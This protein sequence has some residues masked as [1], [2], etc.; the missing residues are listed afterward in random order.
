MGV[1]ISGKGVLS[2]I[3]TLV[4]G[5]VNNFNLLVTRVIGYTNVP[6]TG[7]STY[8]TTRVGS[9]SP[10]FVTISRTGSL[11]YSTNGIEWTAA[12]TG[13]IGQWKSVTFGNNKFVAIS[14]SWGGQTA[15]SSDGITWS[16]GTN[17][18]TGSYNPVVFGN[19]IFVTMNIDGQF[20]YS[21]DGQTW[22]LGAFFPGPWYGFI[23]FG[24]NIF[25]AISAQGQTAYSLDG[26]TWS[27]GTQTVSGFNRAAVF[28]NGVF[29]NMN[30]TGTPIYS[31]DAITWY[32]GN[33]IYQT[34]AYTGHI[35]TFA[36][37]KFILLTNEGLT[38]YS[39]DGITWSLAN[40]SFSGSWYNPPVIGNDILSSMSIGGQTM[41]STDGITWS[42]GNI[43]EST[44]GT[45]FKS[46]SFGNN[47]FTNVSLYGEIAYSTDGITWSLGNPVS[48]GMSSGIVF[49]T[50]TTYV[51]TQILIGDS[52]SGGAEVLAPVDVYTVPVGKTTSIDEIRIKNNS[53]NQITYDLGVL[54]SGVNL[55]DQNAL[56]NDQAIS[57]GATTTLTSTVGSMSAGQRLVVF[58]SAVDVVEVKVYGTETSV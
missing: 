58:P 18:G 4:M 40:S 11:S 14:D 10:G 41:Y 21:L 28:G 13:P 27:L 17:F 22:S 38:G 50:I 5:A 19:G 39:T 49:G 36:M 37:N 23:G 48:G 56:I 31:T 34:P 55:S 29:V 44:D 25:T 57:A 46:I 24:N 2:G 47:I 16:L 42:L 7:G 52:G 26:Q 9:S 45:W 51:E 33:N 20:V 15:Y 43:V 12:E 32:T 53:L 30:I 6:S 8:Y 3:A 35:L 54:S 1:N